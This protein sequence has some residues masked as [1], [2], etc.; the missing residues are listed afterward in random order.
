MMKS[1]LDIHARDIRPGTYMI[2]GRTT[3]FI[4]SVVQHEESLSMTILKTSPNEIGIF[5]T[6][7][8]P[9]SLWIHTGVIIIPT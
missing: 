6:S 1:S 9:E 7:T 4:V 2:S 3:Y 5:Q 8:R